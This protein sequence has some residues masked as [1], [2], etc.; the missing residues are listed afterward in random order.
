MVRLKIP[1]QALFYVMMMLFLIIAPFIMSCS[2]SSGG[3][4]DTPAQDTTDLP[5]GDNGSLDPVISGFDF[6][7]KEGDFWE[8]GWDY[9]SSYTDSRSSSSSSYSSTFRVTLG[10]TLTFDGVTYYEMLISGTTDAGDRKN[11]RPHGAYISVSDDKIV[12][13]ASD[14]K[15]VQTLFD[16]QTGLWP[17]SGFFTSFPDSTL[18]SASASTIIN[19]YISEPAYMVRESESSSQCEYFPGTGRICGGDY[20]EDMDDK[21]YYIEAVGP[22][23][24]YAHYSISDPS[25]SDGGWWASNTTHIGLTE[26]SL[27]GDILDYTLEIEPNNQISEATPITLPAKVRGDDVSETY[28]G[29]TT[30]VSVSIP[31]MT[32]V[33][34]NDSPFVPQTVDIP[35]SITADA[36]DGDTHKSVAVSASP[37]SPTYTATFEDWYQITLGSSDTLNFTLD[38][39]GTE[40]DLDMYLFTLES[41]TEVVA[42]ANSADDNV[43]SGIFHEEMSQYLSADTYYVA[44]DAYDT[45]NGRADYTLVIS[46]GDAY[47]DISDWYSFSLASEAQVTI[48]VTGG[49]NFVLMDS[50]GSDTIASGGVA[51]TSITLSA[52]SYLIGIS[53]SGPYTLEVTS[54]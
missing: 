1:Y 52:G 39:P 45:S 5:P 31:S 50:A 6:T 26:C 29:G 28:L 43:N 42:H 4:G 54:P 21:E 46:T 47:I 8:Y 35:S 17:G 32:E 18:F 27:K 49:P 51:G 10:S 16:A 2:S 53:D 23:G 24:Y 30:A 11:L 37:T 44:I 48:T 36:Q 34:P 3:N 12:L 41:E 40:A 33:E 25:S 7:L 9:K 38:F 14:G 20:N 13:L 22:A 15:T 19:D